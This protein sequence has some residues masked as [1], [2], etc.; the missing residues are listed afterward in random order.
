MKSRKIEMFQ[1]ISLGSYLVTVA[2]SGMAHS[3][4][5]DRPLLYA[6]GA[7]A[8]N[9]LRAIEVIR[10]YTRAFFDKYLKGLKGTLLDQAASRY[11][12]VTIEHFQPSR[13]SNGQLHK[14]SSKGEQ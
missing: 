2:T 6:G 5:C 9:P 1:S 4:F 11:S 7:Q 10:A 13:R 8:A 14:S 3:S 12:E